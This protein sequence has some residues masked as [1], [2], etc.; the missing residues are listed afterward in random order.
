MALV[1]NTNVASLNTQR[2]LMQS[3]QTL[4]Q[5]T[6]RLASGQR[7]NSAK[8]D[9]AGL[10]ISN[11]M[12]SQIRGLDQAVRNA[13]DGISMIQTAEGALQEGTNILQRMREL[14]VQSANGIYSDGDRDT[15]NAEVQQLKTELNRIAEETTFN[16]QALLDGSLNNTLLQVGSQ[17][18]Q[19]ISVSVG[20]FSTSN[21]GGGSG[22]IV[23]E[24]VTNGVADLQGLTS[25]GSIIVNGVTLETAATG[26]V[27]QLLESING[28]L[29]GK[30][31]QVSVQAELTAGSAG[32]GVL[33]AGS[34]TLTIGV[35]DGDGNAQSYIVSGTNNMDEL[36]AKIND[37]TGVEATLDD[38]GQLVLTADGATD[39]TAT[40]SAGGGVEGSGFASAGT[41]ANFSLVFDDTSAEQSGVIIQNDTSADLGLNFQDANGNLLGDTIGTAG[42][43]GEGDL[44]INDVAINAFD[45][46]T[47]AD[48]VSAIN[49][50]SEDTGVVA[51]AS[52]AVIGL[53]SA[54]G[55]EISV[56]YG[57]NATNVYAATGLRERNASE[58]VGSIAS[59]DISTFEGAQKAI[60][61][62][63]QAI[64]QVGATRPRSTTA[65][66]SPYPT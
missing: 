27:N 16:G 18:N 42:A 10:A 13:N 66:T 46:T 64:E 38:R 47:L 4:D 51:F 57:D 23:G 14:S 15:L 41:T 36:V 3:S 7:I 63:D 11:R 53:R 34:D 2:Q 33:R 5:A 40:A 8:D 39:I 55:D 21:L 12:T 25:G 56:K 26:N 48:A 1:I 29:E 17:Q 20:S 9:A 60:G 62:I 22:D 52:G 6:E 43:V 45:S 19:T 65:W 30:G 24:A 61:V 31:A 50:V 37:E 32:S 49:D 54:N 59:V 44:I 35:T 28:Q 58:G